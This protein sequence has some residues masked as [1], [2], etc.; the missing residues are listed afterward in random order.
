MAA[1]KAPASRKATGRRA[2]TCDSVDSAR[3][4]QLQLKIERFLIGDV[5]RSLHRRGVTCVVG[6][7]EAG[8]GPLA[9]PVTVAAVALCPG[10]LGWCE[11]LDDSKALR[12]SERERLFAIV[13]ERALAWDILHLS[14][15]EVDRLNILQASLEGM[16]RVSESVRGA[17][18]ADTWALID[19]NR[20]PPGLASPASCL[21]KGDARSYAIAA[22]SVLA[23]V[24][25]DRVMIELD[26]TYPG[27]GFARHKGY[28]TRAHMA[29]LASL[30]A[31]PE[32]RRSFAPVAAAVARAEDAKPG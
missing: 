23:K 18:G 6:A 9:G 5:E 13:Q 7:D 15:A 29:A 8:R 1:E 24:A 19:G 26:A 31:C 32:H 4:E 25:R 3:D 21:V 10:D 30:G 17:V 27:Y 12:L 2:R 14:A 11:G 16:R 20:L 22:A 28:P